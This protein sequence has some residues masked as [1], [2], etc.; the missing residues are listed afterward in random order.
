MSNLAFTYNEIEG[1]YDIFGS[2]GHLAKSTGL[3]SQILASHFVDSRADDSE[4]PIK[5]LQRGWAGNIIISDIPNYEMG[6]KQWIYTEQAKTDTETAETIIDT[7][8]NDGVQWMIDDK[9][10]QDITIE[11]YEINSKEG[12]IILDETYKIDENNIEKKRVTLW[13]NTSFQ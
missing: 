2:S 5:E 7:I 12:Y 11:L 9:I 4:Q 13:R 6:C 1:Y 8:R 10:Y 3:D